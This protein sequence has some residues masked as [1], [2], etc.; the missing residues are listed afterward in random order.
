MNFNVE[1]EFAADIA[2][3]TQITRNRLLDERAAS[4]I[5]LKLGTEWP[6]FS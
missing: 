6:T 1:Q 5:L 3:C 4:A 2:H